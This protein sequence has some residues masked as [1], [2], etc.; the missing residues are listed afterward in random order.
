MKGFKRKKFGQC[1]YNMFTL[2][3]LNDRPYKR[4]VSG[5]WPS[6]SLELELLSG[7]EG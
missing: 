7:C 6:S 3:S 2:L 4:L 5:N 1:V